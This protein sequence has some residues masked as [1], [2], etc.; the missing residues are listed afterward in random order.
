MPVERPDTFKVFTFCE[1]E[2]YT[3]RS[4]NSGNRTQ[5]FI[6]QFHNY[7]RASLTI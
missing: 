2:N 5:K 3:S 1:K 4:C 7:F 6:I